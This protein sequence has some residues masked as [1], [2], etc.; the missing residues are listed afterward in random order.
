MQFK[1]RNKKVIAI[2]LAGFILTSNISA[3]VSFA[4]VIEQTEDISTTQ[5]INTNQNITE[6]AEEYNNDIYATDNDKSSQNISEQSLS[7]KNTSDST[8]EEQNNNENY[9]LDEYQVVVEG[10][11]IKT[12]AQA[13]NGFVKDGNKWRFYVNNVQAKGWIDY[14]G[15]KYY[16]IN[17][18]TLPQNMWRTIQGHRYY[19]NKDGVMIRDQKILIDG[20]EYQFDKNG[21]LVKNDNT[22]KLGVV[23]AEQQEIYKKGEQILKDSINNGKNIVKNGLYKED[24]KWYKYE[25]GKRTRGWYQEG[26]KRYF[27]LN[28][29]NR[30]E[31]MWR[32][33]NGVRYYF[34]S[35][36]SMISNQIR[37]IDGKTYKFNSDGSLN[38]NVKTTVIQKNINARSQADNTSSVIGNF[39]KGNG[40]VI[41]QE[42]SG[43]AKVQSADG[44][45]QGWVP[46]TS[47]I[48]DSE[49]KINDVIAVAKSKIGSAYVWGATG[50]NTFD[51][52]GLML[53][54]FKKGANY[55]LPRVS[56]Q[57]ATVGRYVSRS[58]LRPGDL[59]FWGS[60]I[61]HV[62]MYIGDGKYIHAPEPGT[63]VRIATL[64][65]YTTARRIIQ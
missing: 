42:K 33:I 55:N 12:S 8:S 54:S 16:I 29:L 28:T 52:S 34:D 37:Y 26:N 20:K 6:E 30:A 45:I 39:I 44:K 61:H 10:K 27:F 35:D 3:V 36:G 23:T 41:L 62:G 53:Y 40:V 57:Q 13:I 14:K 15:I 49:K 43:Y 2:A 4:D 46:S 22:K 25:N 18:Y 60:P 31:N 5:N 48:T 50:P 19:F 56:R 59:V 51:C 9:T 24:G 17:T 7:D 32:T 63:S 65:A 64:G 1:N 11:A 21:H 58:E 38:T 47:Y